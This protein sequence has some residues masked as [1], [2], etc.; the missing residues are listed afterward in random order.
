PLEA[1]G[2]TP[3]GRVD[4]L[5]PLVVP[6]LL[7]IAGDS[8]PERRQRP[9]VGA[10]DNDA[11]HGDVHGRIV[12]REGFPGS[13]MAA[14]VGG[15]TGGS[16]RGYSVGGGDRSWGWAFWASCRSRATRRSR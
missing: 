15:W 5:D 9:R 14:T 13:G 1:D 12:A 16:A 7:A 3:P 2:H 4:E 8:G 6:V 10:V 11:P